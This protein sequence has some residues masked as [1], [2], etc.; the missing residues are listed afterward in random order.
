MLVL[1]IVISSS[2][3][4]LIVVGWEKIEKCR[5]E[6]EDEREDDVDINEHE[7]D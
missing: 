1:V 2:G 3:S 4:G 6:V 5:P 7:H